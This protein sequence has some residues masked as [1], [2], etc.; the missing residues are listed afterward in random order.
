MSS[1]NLS[2]NV[3]DTNRQVRYKFDNFN[4]QIV[5]IK[6]N[7]MNK[8]YKL[9]NEVNN[10]RLKIEHQHNDMQIKQNCPCWNI[11]THF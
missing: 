8:T 5:P 10:L 2:P 4:A 3:T 6:A 11:K 9:R 1:Q 7:F